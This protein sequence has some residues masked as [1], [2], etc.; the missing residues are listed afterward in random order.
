MY[1]HLLSIPPSP[2][3]FLSDKVIQKKNKTEF[4]KHKYAF[5]SSLKLLETRNYA[6]A[7]T[8]AK[9]HF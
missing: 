7:T 3:R 4:S 8:N 2:C 1:Q 6:A 5:S 9:I